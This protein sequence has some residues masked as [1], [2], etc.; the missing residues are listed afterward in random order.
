MIHLWLTLLGYA[1]PG[2]APVQ[3]GARALGAFLHL[4]KATAG[5]SFGHLHHN[6]TESP[7]SLDLD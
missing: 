4:R 5:M 1:Q 2:L 7:A 3:T 6:L